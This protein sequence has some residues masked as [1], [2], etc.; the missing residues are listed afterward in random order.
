MG[1]RR[2]QGAKRIS[3]RDLNELTGAIYSTVEAPDQWPSVLARIAAALHAKSGLVRMLDLRERR[4]VLSSHHYNLDTDLQTEYCGGLVMNDPYL[5]ALKRLPV[6]QMVTNDGLIDLDRMRDTEFYQ[7]YMR[8]LDNHFIVGGFLERADDGRHSIIGFHRHSGSEQFSRSE[9]RVIQWLAPHV[10]QAMHLQRVLGHHRNR[11]DSA[12]RALDTMAVACLL[13][14][15]QGRMVHANETGERLVRLGCGLRVRDGRVVSDDSRV[16]TM[17]A[18]LTAQAE[19]APAGR[20]C[21]ASRS[22]LVPAAESAAANLLVV[23]MPIAQAVSTMGEEWPAAR[24]AL[25]V[26]DLDDTG[27]LRPEVLCAIY[28]LTPAEARLA[29]AVGRG[30]ELSRLSADWNVSNETLRSQLKAVFAK[31]GVNRQVEL[32]RLLAG[33]PWKVAAPA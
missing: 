24:V 2:R 30:R 8:P 15:R 9:L 33:A 12:E 23:G 3:D 19:N 28:D 7:E 16:M 17:I 10:K 6:G 4:A 29:V 5:E 31:T 14:D 32:V 20:E 22:V 25:Y 13:L 18:E 11:A 21:L 1:V 26:G 27:V